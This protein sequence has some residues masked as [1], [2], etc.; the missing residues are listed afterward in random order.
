MKRSKMSSGRSRRSFRAGT[1][2]NGKNV[3]RTPMRGGYR[4]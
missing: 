3:R 1:R 4:L 2:V